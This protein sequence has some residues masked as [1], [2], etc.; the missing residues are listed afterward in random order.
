MKILSLLFLL[1][2]ILIL[3]CTA[4][5]QDWN[6]WHY[7]IDVTVAPQ[8]DDSFAAVYADFTHLLQSTFHQ[9]GALDENSIRV[10][11]LQNG[12]PEM[13]VSYQFVE[14]DDYDATANAA[15]TLVFAVKG[16]VDNTANYRIYFDTTANGAKPAFQYSED[17]TASA[18][19]IWNGSFEILSQDYRGAN[20]YANSGENMP[21]GWWGNLK[22]IGIVE[23][24]AATPHNGK[25]AIGLVAPQNSHVSIV[26][27]PSPPAL[28][29]QPGEN[30][31]FS[32]WIK[33]ENLT[34]RYPTHASVYWKDKAGKLVQRVNVDTG[35]GK[36]A[37]YDW[38][39]VSVYLSAPDN[40]TYAGLYI[41]TYSATGLL[42]VDD[43]VVRA[44]V[45]PLLQ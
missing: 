3:P 23:N 20:R 26:A 27:A 34:G 25:H 43:L 5:A 40:A 6:Q 10:A 21:R 7:H 32:F 18:N 30:Y 17:V 16:A 45:P 12:R 24:N 4:H 42:T 38:T 14:A 19:M 44:A 37:D 36:A 15:G 35:V 28:R 1:L 13:P 29:V 39:H 2:Y 33:G 9:P 31:L 41:G 11:P 22:N 8:A